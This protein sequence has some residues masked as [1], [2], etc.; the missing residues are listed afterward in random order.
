[1]TISHLTV[2]T[3]LPHLFRP[4]THTG[5]TR[6]VHGLRDVFAGVELLRGEEGVGSKPFLLYLPLFLVFQVNLGRILPKFA[7][8]LRCVHEAALNIVRILG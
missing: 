5:V 2:L 6:L 3:L 1:M 7:H 4:G 8:F